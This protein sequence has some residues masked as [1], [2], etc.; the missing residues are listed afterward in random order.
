M[1][2]QIEEYEVTE[3]QTHAAEGA[4]GNAET[5]YGVIF[6]RLSDL[7]ATQ[8]SVVAAIT[9]MF[10]LLR[11]F[12]AHIK[13]LNNGILNEREVYRGAAA[14]ER[15]TNVITGDMASLI[16]AEQAEE[17]AAAHPYVGLGLTTE[18][19]AIAYLNLLR[20]AVSKVE[21]SLTPVDGS[22]STPDVEFLLEIMMAAGNYV[23]GRSAAGAV[24]SGVDTF[25]TNY[26][27]A[28]S[29]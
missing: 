15:L 3:A 27:D 1:P 2:N 22:E 12:D 8:A 28:Y 20:L 11:A 9:E 4:T 24:G 10:T 14:L 17:A 25:V 16:E 19:Q 26:L 29:D 21:P 5:P 13:Q 6:R 18:E 7:E 23:E